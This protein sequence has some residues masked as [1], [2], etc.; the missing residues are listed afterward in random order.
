M[1]ESSLNWIITGNLVSAN[2]IFT[3]NF[4]EY[5]I[6]FIYILVKHQKSLDS[7]KI[8]YGFSGPEKLCFSRFCD[9]KIF[10]EIFKF[11]EN[12]SA[13]LHTFGKSILQISRKCLFSKKDAGKK[14]SNKIK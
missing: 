7:K 5:C 9:L 14:F 12:R 8:F 2:C 11:L 3:Q 10:K 6:F 4:S 1:A 13:T